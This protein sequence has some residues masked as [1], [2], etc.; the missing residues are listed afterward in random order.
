[1]NKLFFAV[2][3]DDYRLFKEFKNNTFFPDAELW[4]VNNIDHVRGKSFIGYTILQYPIK[5]ST[6]KLIYLIRERINPVHEKI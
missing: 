5:E 4:M 6:D 1:M 3:T 2:I